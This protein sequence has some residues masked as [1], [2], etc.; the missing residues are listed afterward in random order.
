MSMESL[1]VK[2]EELV[3]RKT[4]CKAKFIPASR[5]QL[6]CATCRRTL[7]RDRTRKRREQMRMAGQ[8]KEGRF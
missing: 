1:Y 6:Y 4:T 5:N 3:C 2:K 7:N 8:K